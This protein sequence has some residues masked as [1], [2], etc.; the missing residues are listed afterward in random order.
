MKVIQEIVN[1]IAEKSGFPHQNRHYVLGGD[2]V[3]QDEVDLFL[4]D[5]SAMEEDD[6]ED[7]HTSTRA[8]HQQ[9]FSQFENLRV[10]MDE[11]ISLSDVGGNPEA[12][13]EVGKIIKSIK[14]SEIMRSWGAKPT[15]GIVFE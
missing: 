10:K 7:Y 6:D 13:E 14:F 12:K 4:D 2:F 5:L 8:G 11:Q 1:R 3:L 9:N 15:S